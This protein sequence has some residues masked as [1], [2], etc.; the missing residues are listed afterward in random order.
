MHPDFE[1]DPE[2]EP[3]PAEWLAMGEWDRIAIC[4]L[5]HRRAGVQ[6]PDRAM[7]GHAVIHSVVESQVAAGEPAAAA[8]ALARLRAEGLSRHDAIHAVGSVLAAHLHALLAAPTMPEKPNAAY[9]DALKRLTV[10]SWRKS[11]ES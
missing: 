5:W 10:E 6:L 2:T 9:Q 4:D 1:Y 7:Q 11:A 8:E 3:D